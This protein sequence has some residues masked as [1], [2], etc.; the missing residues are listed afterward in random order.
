MKLTGKLIVFSILAV[1][2]LAGCN[3]TPAEQPEP[4]VDKTVPQIIFIQAPDEWD[5]GETFEIIAQATVEEG[6]ISSV[7]LFYNDGTEHNVAM[8]ATATADQYSVSL[9]APEAVGDKITYYAIADT[10]EDKRTETETFTL[11]AAEE[12]TT[13]NPARR[14][15][16]SEIGTYDIYK[17]IEIYNPSGMSVSLEGVSLWKNGELLW[18]FDSSK[19]MWARNYGVLKAKDTSIELSAG[20]VDLGTTEI[21]LSG[22]K[23]LSVELRLG[24]QVIDAFANTVNPGVADMIIDDW[25]G[26]VEYADK[27]YCT[28]IRKKGETYGWYAIAYNPGTKVQGTPGAANGT[29]GTRLK[30]QLL[31][32]DAEATAPYIANIVINP[33]SPDEGLTPSKNVLQFSV[34]SDVHNP[35][36]TVECS[37]GTAVHVSGTIYRV[38]PNLS[39][40]AANGKE[41]A[42]T[43]TAVNDTGTSKEDIKVYA[44]QEGQEFGSYDKICLNEILTKDGDAIELYNKSDKPVVIGGMR[45]RKNKDKIFAIPGYMVL[46]AG[47]Y[48]VLGCNGKGYTGASALN[49]G[50]VSNGISGS[51]S[52]LIELRRRKIDNEDNTPNV[53]YF[54]NINTTYT[55]PDKDSP[56]DMEG[57][58][59]YQHTF[60]GAGRHPDGTGS[61]FILTPATI[62]SSNASATKGAQFTQSYNQ[63]L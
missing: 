63:D 12:G 26:E 18:E 35:S 55:R 3:K 61:W 21:G 6:S 4:P 7:T 53:D 1:F 41:T 16:L 45:I 38:S 32:A 20:A 48:A 2:T 8:T 23:S 10:A 36:V 27:E 42:I 62:G 57:A 9:T 22:S 59:Y 39:S 14:L 5:A 34:Y 47:G 24:D 54:V 50:T 11:T 56:W 30:H 31:A 43:L 19:K 28:F 49:L 25:D 37:L 17:F 29:V 13:I 33:D 40:T 51:K 46:R 52:L 44:F 60:S 58:S 15:R